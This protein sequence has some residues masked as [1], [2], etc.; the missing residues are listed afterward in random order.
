MINP[1]NARGLATI[2]QEIGADISSGDLRYP[3]ET[4]GWQFGDLDLSE[5]L[6]RYR[7][8]QV[9]VIIASI[10]PAPEP[11][12]TC[13]ICGFVYNEYGE[14]PRCKVVGKGV[15]RSVAGGGDIL[16]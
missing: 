4:G 5:Y 8:Q 7:D 1:A 2:A 12:Y 16:D 6:D 9:I 15:T 10:G 14:C 11:S 13:G 3:S